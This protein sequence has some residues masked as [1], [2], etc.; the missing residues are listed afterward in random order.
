LTSMPGLILRSVMVPFRGVHSTKRLL[1]WIWRTPRFV[2]LRWARSA[3]LRARIRV[4]SACSSCLLARYHFQ[5][6]FLRAGKYA[7]PTL[8]RLMHFHRLLIPA[9][10]RGYPISL[11]CHPR[12]L[13]Y[14]FLQWRQSLF[15][16]SVKR[17]G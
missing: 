9:Q 15:L 14:Q 7:W 1:A 4:S 5:T 6:I 3:S 11:I 2:N 8:N 10:A 16:Q 12:G 17:H 13:D